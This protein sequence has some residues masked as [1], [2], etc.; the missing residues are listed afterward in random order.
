MKRSIKRRQ[1][2]LQEGWSLVRAYIPTY[3]MTKYEDSHLD[4]KQQLTNKAASK[5]LRG[6]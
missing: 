3:M 6:D 2:L 4:K 1:K 5:G